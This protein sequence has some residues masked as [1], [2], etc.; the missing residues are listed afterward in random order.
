[1]ENNYFKKVK[2]E[3]EDRPHKIRILSQW[4]FITLNT[5]KSIIDNSNKE[6]LNYLKKFVNCTT[7]SEFQQLFDTIQGQFG[8]HH[9]SQKHGSN[10]KYLCSLVADFPV[11]TL[12]SADHE[13]INAFLNVNQYLL[14][15]L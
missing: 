12:T 14:Y 2:I 6:Q 8:N 10:Y 4:L 1:M 3:L 11:T 7:T 5:A 13:S 9:F 15:E